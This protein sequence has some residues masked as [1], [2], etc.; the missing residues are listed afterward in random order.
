MSNTFQQLREMAAKKRDDAIKAAKVEFNE[1]VQKIA[2]LETRL[3]G[4][5]RPR[6]GARNDGKPKLA[7][8]I[9]SVLPDDR[10]FTLTDVCGFVEAA[11]PD[12]KWSRQTIYTNLNRFLKAGAIKRIAHAGHKRAAIFALP[13][14]PFEEAKTMLDWAN[15]VIADSDCELTPVE[16]MV[17]MTERGYEMDV[18]PN[19]AVRSLERELSKLG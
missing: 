12:R 1:T 4:K 9:Y 3:K 11:E 10:P 19:D 15:E 17:E 8:L 13:D 2:E 7:D 14:V 18:P 6:P 5:R 16:I